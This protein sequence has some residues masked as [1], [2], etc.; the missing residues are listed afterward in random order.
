MRICRMVA[1][2]LMLVATLWSCEGPAP[3]AWAETSGSTDIW[4]C[5]EEPTGADA[6]VKASSNKDKAAA[7]SRSAQ[8]TRDARLAR[9]GDR[10]SAI[11]IG[12]LVV[13]SLIIVA[14]GLALRGRLAATSALTCVAAA[15]VFLLCVMSPPALADEGVLDASQDAIEDETTLEE[16]SV[17]AVA[18]A[19]DDAA[20]AVPAVDD[21]A[22]EEGALVWL[23]PN[24]AAGDVAVWEFGEEALV[25]PPC[26][27]EYERHEFSG[28]SLDA[29][30]EG[31]RY[32]P[33]T[34]AALPSGE[35]LYA[36]WDLAMPEGVQDLDFSSKRLIVGM[37]DEPAKG[38]VVSACDGVWCM[39]FNTAEETAWAYCDLFDEAEFIAPDQTLVVAEAFGDAQGESVPADL[40]TLDEPT[41]EYPGAIALI[42]TGVTGHSGN[43]LER[44]SV[45]GITV[46]DD[47]GHG[48]HMADVM[49]RM[50]PEAHIV[51]IKAAD[52]EGRASA[53]SV[54]VA[55]HRAIDMRV[56]VVNLSLCAPALE[57]N[58][59]VEQAIRD[60]HEAGVIVVGAAGNDARDA[61]WYVPGKMVDEAV[62]VGSCD[63]EGSRNASSNFG[64]SVDLYVPSSSTSVAAAKVSAWLAL[65]SSPGNEIADLMS[66]VAHEM[67]GF[68]TEVEQGTS[69]APSTSDDGFLVA[70]NSTVSMKA[71]WR[72]HSI[73]EDTWTVTGGQS[74]G[75]YDTYYLQHVAFMLNKDEEDPEGGIGYQAYIQEIGPSATGV[76]GTTAADG[77]V[78][79][80]SEDLAIED[81]RV[82]LTGTID[83]CYYIRYRSTCAPG[84]E[85]YRG[86]TTIK[87]FYGPDL[88]RGN[89]FYGQRGEWTHVD[90][91]EAFE[92][93]YVGPDGASEQRS[94]AENVIDSASVPLMK[95][96][97]VRL[98]KKSYHHHVWVRYQNVDGS[99]GNYDLVRD[100]TVSYK[101]TVSSWNSGASTIYKRVT[102][103]SYKAGYE[104]RDNYI[105]VPRLV[106]AVGINVYDPEGVETSEGA[107]EHAAVF[108][109]SL[110]GGQ[111]WLCD[112]TDEPSNAGVLAEQTV[113]LRNVRGTSGHSVSQIE[114][115]TDN[116]DGTYSVTVD[117]AKTIAIRTTRAG[118]TV[119]FDANAL[120]ATGTMESLAVSG[121][122]AVSIPTCA[123]E[124]AAYE[125]VAWN[126]KTD[127]T[128]RWLQAGSVVT[129][130]FEDGETVVTLYAQ[131]NPK[132]L[133]VVAPV[134]LEYVA[135]SDGTLAGPA[136]GAVQVK[137]LGT[138]SVRI[139]ETHA[140]INE[141][142]DAELGFSL[143]K[144]VLVSGESAGLVNVRGSMN[145]PVVD[146]T[147]IGCIR[148]VFGIE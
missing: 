64:E 59:V 58:A 115:A 89:Q 27:F 5:I 54:Y 99:Y 6:Q 50:C 41:R 104:D 108:D 19:V 76:A 94:V 4:V 130:L 128:G 136:D 63:S 30:G 20:S 24:G 70:A 56:K 60:A 21:A 97:E 38:T 110:D 43:V 134:A 29:D 7:Q 121:G 84:R 39:S 96:D 118:S 133:H 61:K 122:A 98:Y 81:I 140:E 117:T 78:C 71:G 16:P 100:K 107:G 33:Q 142:Y 42:D 12:A 51:S 82:W 87:D 67:L 139:Q 86:T 141:G 146:G 72:G 34:D 8:A 13:A 145:T 22:Q 28:W 73:D 90:N 144:N 88:W 47:S 52:A 26:P 148:W 68:V 123:F 138:T 55:I 35:V 62:I 132:R 1:S 66:D 91:H 32:V 106:Y 102:M 18:L 45:I 23:D 137:N 53:S 113:M 127:G 131:W 103:S 3:M 10:T 135:K 69:D 109:L 17:E 92:Y 57:G 111:T 112:L 49:V 95:I 105:S 79:G 9:T 44:T 65:Y 31:E 125:F 80:A 37:D 119:Q 120:D 124:R 2:A 83:K 114:G 77:Q 93:T 143:E 14:C 46:I 75:G 101:G 25:V 85:Y 129:D 116:G 147:E 74:A 40:A 11:V 15:I 36:Q 48:T 126:T